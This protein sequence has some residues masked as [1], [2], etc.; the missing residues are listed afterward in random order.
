M[1]E[2]SSSSLDQVE[3]DDPFSTLVLAPLHQQQQQ[4]QQRGGGCLGSGRRVS[5]DPEVCELFRESD[6]RVTT[7]TTT[8]MRCGEQRGTAKVGA[9]GFQRWQKGVEGSQRSSSALLSKTFGSDFSSSSNRCRGGQLRDLNQVQR[10][11]LDF[12]KMQV[13]LQLPLLISQNV[14]FS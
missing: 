11:S 4:N 8:M 14:M 12:D 13:S 5:S 10:P 7:T 2:A 9:A 1:A 3:N 6:V